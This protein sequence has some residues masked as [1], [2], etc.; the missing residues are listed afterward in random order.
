[1]ASAGRDVT[2]ADP[3][4]DG[5]RIGVDIGGTFT[6]V[7][8]IAPGGRVHFQKIASTPEHP[9]Q[10]VITGIRGVLEETGIAPR[11]V[12]EVLH[13]TTVGSNAVLEKTGARAG[14]ITTRGFRDVLEIGRLRTPEMFDLGW[15]KPEPLVERRLRREVRGRIAADGSEVEPMSEAELLSVTRELLEEGVD[16]IA[17][18]FINSYRN[19]AH[20]QVSSRSRAAAF[21]C[22]I[23][24]WRARPRTSGWSSSATSCSTGGP[25]WAMS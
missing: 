13:G 21:R 4:G 7:V 2:H 3:G 6:D 9:E 20:E 12:S 22:A 17:L 1:V 15:D 8:V 19:P 25:S 14:L 16:S 5:V 11:E 24:R 23:G 10:A 18:C